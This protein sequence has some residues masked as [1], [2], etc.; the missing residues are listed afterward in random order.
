MP[1]EDEQLFDDEQIQR[2][3]ADTIRNRYGDNWKHLASNV[4]QVTQPDGSIVKG[5]DQIQVSQYFFSAL[6]L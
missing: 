4:R 6:Y 5:K 3:D 1:N 2:F